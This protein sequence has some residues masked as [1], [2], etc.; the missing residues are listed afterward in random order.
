MVGPM[1]INSTLVMAR[2]VGQTSLSGSLFLT[3]K[4][5]CHEQMIIGLQVSRFNNYKNYMEHS[6]GWN[7]WGPDGNYVALRD[8]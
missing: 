6:C 2:A 4:S 3:C 7:N 1:R 5:F 8:H